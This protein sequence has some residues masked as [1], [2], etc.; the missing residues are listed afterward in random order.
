MKLKKLFLFLALLLVST[1][2]FAT[3]RNLDTAPI[4]AV[5]ENAYVGYLSTQMATLG[6]TDTISMDFGTCPCV[7]SE[8]QFST[9]NTVGT[10][11]NDFVQIMSTWVSVGNSTYSQAIVP[12]L[13]LYNA[14]VLTSST[15]LST[16][17]NTI[18]AGPVPITLKAPLRIEGNSFSIRMSARLYNWVRISYQSIK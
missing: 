12:V 11:Q 5:T 18:A 4:G 9:P 17:A 15:T 3:F 14:S 7:I 16:T 10:S 6:S 2:A 1:P 8:V 13:T